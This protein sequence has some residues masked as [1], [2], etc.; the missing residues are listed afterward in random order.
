M[1][2]FSSQTAIHLPN[3]NIKLIKTGKFHPSALNN[4]TTFFSYR[5]YEDY[6]LF[7]IRKL[8]QKT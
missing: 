3:I 2:T 5:N 6:N 8:Q 4:F 7:D 1:Y